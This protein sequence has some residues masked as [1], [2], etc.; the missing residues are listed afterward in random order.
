MAA[1]RQ[2][3]LLLGLCILVAPSLGQALPRLALGDEKARLDFFPSLDLGSHTTRAGITGRAVFTLIDGAACLRGGGFA[4]ERFATAYLPLDG[5]ANEFSFG[6]NLALGLGP[7]LSAPAPWTDFEP[8]RRWEL[9]YEWMD[10]LDGWGTDQL[11]GR[12]ELVY[13]RQDWSLGLA[14]HDDLFGLKAR[15]EWRTAAVELAAG[16]HAWGDDMALAIG[17]KLWTGS[18]WGVG[19]LYRG[20]TYPMNPALPGYGEDAGILYVGVRRGF[21]RL[22]LGWDSEAIRDVLQNGTHWLID[23]GAVPLTGRADRA[24]FALTVY[25][26]GSLY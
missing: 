7:V 8:T 5:A 4:S 13:A 25:P 3:V 2:A 12:L 17:M 20:Q 16:F 22:E 14:F 1:V 10:Y 21:L 15:D 6:L 19:R 24:Y 26:D 9:R 11:G 23:D 18:T